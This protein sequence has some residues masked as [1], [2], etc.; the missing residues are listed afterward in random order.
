M[1]G[2][3]IQLHI[4]DLH[5][6]KSGE[7]E[8]STPLARFFWVGRSCVTNLQFAND[9][10][11]RLHAIIERTDR[12]H[13]LRDMCSLNGTKVNGRAV[14]SCI[15]AEK[16]VIALGDC[17]VRYNLNSGSVV[18]LAH[19]QKI[20][21]SASVILYQEF[22]S[23]SVN[24]N[25]VSTPAPDDG[26]RFDPQGVPR[27][28]LDEFL[29]LAID[30]TLEQVDGDF[31][32]VLLF[33][34][35]VK[36]LQPVI[37]RARDGDQFVDAPLPQVLPDLGVRTVQ[38]HAQY[39]GTGAGIGSVAAGP[40]AVDSIGAYIDGNGQSGYLHVERR[41]RSNASP[42]AFTPGDRDILTE[43]GRAMDV[44]IVRFRDRAW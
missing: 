20:Q 28:R 29:R 37:A 3:T 14:R 13:V 15:L 40:G 44:V 24:A 39:G 22:R 33:G 2:L 25:P 8:V 1:A 11:S 42:P 10:V 5:G 32:L 16:D 41:M 17:E 21:S 30:R 26:S 38:L 27:P 43:V 31:G 7:C 4:N 18:D 19:G 23:D 6:Q 36:D 34:S 35:A 12:G 9:T